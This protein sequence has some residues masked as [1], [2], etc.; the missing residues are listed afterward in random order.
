MAGAFP[1][2]RS[3]LDTLKLRTT[4]HEICASQKEGLS[5]AG[6]DPVNHHV[7]VTPTFA[8]RILYAG[9]NQDSLPPVF[10]DAFFVIAHEVM[11]G[12]SHR[13]IVKTLGV[14]QDGEVVVEI[15][16]ATGTQV[17][18][19]G[20]CIK[21]EVRLEVL[22]EAMTNFNVR[23]ATKRKRPDVAK[24]LDDLYRQ[25]GFNQD[26]AIVERLISLAGENAVNMAY[27]E[28]KLKP[29]AKGLERASIDATR[30]FDLLGSRNHEK[31]DEH[32]AEGIRMLGLTPDPR[33]FGPE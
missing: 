29:L 25:I 12:I 27:F 22:N 15:G 21:R 20:V 2:R 13:K 32:A 23:R 16:P 3:I 9:K 7:L 18:V 31:R 26:V 17:F 11:H 8:G 4:N 1:E 6:Y 14:D 24:L 19:G 33:L 30:F 10:V 5:E 28:G